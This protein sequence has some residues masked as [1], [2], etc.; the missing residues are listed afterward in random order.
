MQEDKKQKDSSIQAEA[1]F[2]RRGQFYVEEMGEEEGLY[3]GKSRET[4]GE[5]AVADMVIKPRG[6]DRMIWGTCSASPAWRCG[7]SVL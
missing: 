6:D 1:K 7:I 3:T 4:R 2:R 5:A